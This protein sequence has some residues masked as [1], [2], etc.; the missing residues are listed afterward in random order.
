MEKLEVIAERRI[1]FTDDFMF[2]TIMGQESEICRK[3]L[4]CILGFEIESLNYV[5][6]QNTIKNGK[7]A[8][9]FIYH[10]HMHL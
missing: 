5:E 3:V 2:A 7:R 4:E 9:R 6:S 8:K 1:E 10:L